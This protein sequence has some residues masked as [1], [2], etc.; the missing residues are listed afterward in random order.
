MPIYLYT[1]IIP[2][3]LYTYIPHWLQ[4][5]VYLK[6]AKPYV[7]FLNTVPYML[8]IFKGKKIIEVTYEIHRIWCQGR[9]PC[10]S[11]CERTDPEPF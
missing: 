5:W 4:W 9:G 7:R 10:S 8:P 6:T 11:R 3:Y 2:I 1:Y